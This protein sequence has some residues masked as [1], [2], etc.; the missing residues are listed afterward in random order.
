[1]AVGAGGT[2]SHC[3]CGQESEPWILALKGLFPFP[4]VFQSK[5]CSLHIQGRVFPLRQTSRN[6]LTAMPLGGPSQAD[7]EGEQ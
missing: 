7:N 2:W 3:I 5:D 4:R 6:A 1:M